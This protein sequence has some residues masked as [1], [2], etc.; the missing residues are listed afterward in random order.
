MA[1]IV[2]LVVVGLAIG[3]LGGAICCLYDLRHL[4]EIRDELRAIRRALEKRGDG[5]G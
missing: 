1:E 4:S 2:T 3:L 5:D